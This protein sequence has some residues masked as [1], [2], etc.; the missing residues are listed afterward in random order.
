MRNLT[1]FINDACPEQEFDGRPAY[2][3]SA[4]ATP[5]RDDIKKALETSEDEWN[6]TTL[7]AINGV[8]CQELIESIR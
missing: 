6:I 5:D 4:G 1:Q 3:F 8:N 7:L 2:V